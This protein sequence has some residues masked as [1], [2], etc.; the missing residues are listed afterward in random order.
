MNDIQDGLANYDGNL[1]EIN[2]I[3]VL[4]ASS[5]MH[6]IGQVK[7]ESPWQSNYETK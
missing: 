1:A 7:G 2:K 5:F 3:F 4:H 6:E